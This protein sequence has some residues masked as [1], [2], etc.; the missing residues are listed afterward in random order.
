MRAAFSSRAPALPAASLLLGI[1]ML[2]AAG[3]GART[4]KPFTAAGTASCLKGKGFTSVSR[5]AD[6][7]GFI[8]S[9]ATNGGLHAVSP[10]NNAVTVAFTADPDEVDSTE[11]AFR[12]AAPPLIRAH[13]SDVLRSDRNAVIVW[14]TSPSNDDASALSGC[15]AP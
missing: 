1:V 13:L 5:A 6:K 3:C 9:F 15:L 10:E 12:K 4:S 11:R 2:L 14:T 7:V 8:A